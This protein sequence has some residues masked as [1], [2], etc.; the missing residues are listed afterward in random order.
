MAVLEVGWKVSPLR[1]DMFWKESINE[2]VM[3]GSAGRR[4]ELAAEDMLEDDRGEVPSGVEDLDGGILS[5]QL[6]LSAAMQGRPVT[7]LV[8]TMMWRDSCFLGGRGRR[9]EVVAVHLSL[10]TRFPLK[11]R[12]WRVID[13]AGSPMVQ[14]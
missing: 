1:S 13:A 2:G 3:L 8:G 10:G 7:H 9:E 6:A 5:K 12:G 14:D 11:W 4:R